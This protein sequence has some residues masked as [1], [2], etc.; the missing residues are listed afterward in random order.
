[1]FGLLR[2]FLFFSVYPVDIRNIHIARVWSR[3]I[4]YT[5]MLPLMDLF[6]EFK[7]HVSVGLSWLLICN[8]IF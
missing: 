6:L 8:G 7:S 5:Q 3:C 1:M 2:F 4:G